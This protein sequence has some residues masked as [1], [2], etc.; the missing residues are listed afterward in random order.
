MVV[1]PSI[2]AAGVLSG[3][4]PE[5][6]ETRGARFGA[7]LDPTDSDDE[8][9]SKPQPARSLPPR[10]HT[11]NAGIGLPGFDPMGTG[12]PDLSG[13]PP[14]SSAAAFDTSGAGG[15]DSN[16]PDNQRDADDELRRQNP[17]LH[18]KVSTG[19][20]NGCLAWFMFGALAV[21]ILLAPSVSGGV[22]GALT[23][24]VNYTL[25]ASKRAAIHRGGST[26]RLAPAPTPADAAAEQLGEKPP[27]ASEWTL[28]RTIYAPAG[29]WLKVYTRQA[30]RQLSLRAEG[31]VRGSAAEILC[32]LRELDLMPQWNKYTDGTPTLLR[33]VTPT[34]LWAAL[35]VRLPW[36]VPRQSLFVK[37]LVERDPSSKRGIVATAQSTSEVIV[38]PDGVALPD[39]LADRA[40]LPVQLAV[41][42]IRPLDSGAS[43]SGA[44]QRQQRQQPLSRVDVYLTFDLSRLGYLAAAS[45]A[46]SWLVNLIVFIAVP[47]VYHSYLDQL[48][49]LHASG[50]AHLSRLRADHSGL[51]KRVAKWSGQPLP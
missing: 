33:M 51:Y 25:P 30:D 50:S 8:P 18:A 19:T 16:I 48:A 40:E 46:P 10:H 1:G 24:V 39:S 22:Y 29:P 49:T 7:E 5:Q 35:G 17:E 9:D 23:T 41:G 38:P 32:L 11:S 6:A 42:R 47:M 36:P 31:A 28:A 14:G 34:E 21:A 4:A 27:S 44:P 13:M 3:V 15:L 2:N 20:L 45:A 37:A 43:A 26:P 12:L